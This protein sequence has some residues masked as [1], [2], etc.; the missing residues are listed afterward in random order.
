MH[1]DLTLYKTWLTQFDSVG[2]PLFGQEALSEGYLVSPI[3][4][5]A[6]LGPST[7]VAC[8]GLHRQGR[9]QA[10]GKTFEV[11]SNYQLSPSEKASA[12]LHDTLTMITRKD[13][14]V[15]RAWV[16]FSFGIAEL[17]P[18]WVVGME[19]MKGRGISR[20]KESLENILTWA[21]SIDDQQGR[22]PRKATSIAL[23]RGV[24]LASPTEESA[25][26]NLWQ[27]RLAFA[28]PPTTTTTKN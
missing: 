3:N 18:T 20:E 13:G 24:Y 7:I 2:P 10:A 25:R 14:S 1:P 27:R 21:G 9:V 11:Y 8:F 6:F 16:Y 26:H 12:N 4:P 23:G 28:R 19:V 22:W 15:E 5:Y 17:Y